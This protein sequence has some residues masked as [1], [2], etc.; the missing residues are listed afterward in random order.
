MRTTSCQMVG[1]RVKS[2]CDTE[3]SFWDQTTRKSKAPWL[4]AV[5]VVMG[6]GL[7]GKDTETKEAL[8]S[9]Y[10]CTNVM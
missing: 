5:Y 10:V 6:K 9:G 1:S 7:R 2:R 4:F 8:C 3:M